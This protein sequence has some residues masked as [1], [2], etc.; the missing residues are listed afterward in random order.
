MTED[1]RRLFVAKERQE[2][3][4][5]TLI[6]L[7][8]LEALYNYTTD[9]TSDQLKECDGDIPVVNSKNYEGQ[10]NSFA[11][12][13]SEG[14]TELLNSTRSILCTS[15]PVVITNSIN[16]SA[17][18]SSKADSGPHYTA[19]ASPQ[20]ATPPLKMC[21]HVNADDG[22][23]DDSVPADSVERVAGQIAAAVVEPSLLVN[24]ADSSR[25]AA[26]LSLLPK[27]E[28]DTVMARR[29]VESCPLA[30]ARYRYI[31]RI[32]QAKGVL[33]V[34][35]NCS[36]EDLMLDHEISSLAKQLSYCYLTLR[37]DEKCAIQ[38]HLTSLDI[39]SKLHSAVMHHGHHLWKCHSHS[40]LFFEVFK[41]E[42][43]IV[44][45]PDA[46]TELSNALDLT[47]VY[48]IG[49]LV[50]KSVS[51]NQSAQQAARF[52]L[53]SRKLPLRKYSS[54]CINS[55]L[56]VNHV[57]DILNN[58]HQTGNWREAIENVLPNRKT[59]T[60]SRFA[61]REKQSCG[62]TP[63]HQRNVVKVARESEWKGDRSYE[64]DMTSILE[65][66]S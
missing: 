61:R 42:D 24:D 15:A 35:V 32:M 40:D 55:V 7:H 46:E 64:V 51:K 47:K 11:G 16:P 20:S 2:R 13:Q 53:Q 10:H 54:Q 65:E 17:M 56:N 38:M 57:F 33:R 18:G 41:D 28:V 1:E 5:A 6:Q 19:V 3:A 66:C 31:D 59:A 48:V 37:R 36:F 63:N 60:L 12:M 14:S 34:C 62:V 25:S 44:L 30:S 52:Q 27:S 43:I 58:V 8:R 26:D 39:D 21:R 50:D 29:A 9:E 4:V 22:P 23:I 45:T 49:G